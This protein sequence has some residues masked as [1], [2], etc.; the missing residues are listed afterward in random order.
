M[1]RL[2]YDMVIV[3]AMRLF[4]RAVTASKEMQYN[5]FQEYIQYLQSMGWTNAEFDIEMLKRIDQNWSDIR[6]N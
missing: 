2:P 5:Y 4:D 6:I 1:K 3:E